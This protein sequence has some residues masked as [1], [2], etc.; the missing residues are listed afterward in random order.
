MYFTVLDPKT[1]KLEEAVGPVWGK[2]EVREF[3]KPVF[4][5]SRNC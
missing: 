4:E 2:P 3:W 1:G 5:A